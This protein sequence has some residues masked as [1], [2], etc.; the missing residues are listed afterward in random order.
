MSHFSTSTA[1]AQTARLKIKTQLQQLMIEAERGAGLTPWEA[2]ILARLVD[3]IFF[4][5]ADAETYR[6]GQLKYSCVKAT[7][8]AGKTLA[9]CEMVT[10]RLTLFD[11]EDHEELPTKSCQRATDMRRRR[12]LR[13][14]DE[15]R[16]QD[17]LL[18]QEDLGELLTCDVRTVRRDIAALK[19]AGIVVATRGTVKDIGPGV[20]HKALA[21]R[22]WLEGKEPT[23]VA[24]R[25]HHS[26]KAVE[27]YLE[28]FK[29]IAYLTEKGFTI[30]E[31][32]RVVGISTAAVQTFKD[33]HAEY[34]NKAFYTYR[35]EEINICGHQFWQAEDEKKSSPSSRK[36]VAGK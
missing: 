31:M 25:I 11:P 18:S 7:E 17:G 21:I 10:V 30:H 26:L 29:R 6:S 22:L 9:Q 4:Q 20:T 5:S 16:E 36:S 14:C 32:A 23:E 24:M 1:E 34:G 19:R 3:E 27:A 15:A 12:L 28:K 35:Q 13:M 2:S 8:P 33:L